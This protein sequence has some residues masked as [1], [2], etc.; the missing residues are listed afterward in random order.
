MA[1]SIALMTRLLLVEHGVGTRSRTL[2]PA[3]GVWGELEERPAGGAIVSGLFGCVGETPAAMFVHGDRVWMRIGSR[4]WREDEIAIDLDRGRITNVLRITTQTGDR[5]AWRYRVP[6]G[7]ALKE[8]FLDWLWMSWPSDWLD[9][10]FGLWLAT[11]ED[12]DMTEHWPHE[13]RPT[14]VA[15]EDERD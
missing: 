3:S 2:D 12:F 1:R 5:H 15:S 11:R 4:Q 13:L 8:G 6:W 9:W 10:D 7:H 14:S